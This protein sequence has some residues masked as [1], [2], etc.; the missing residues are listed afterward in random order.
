MVLSI[1]CWGLGISSRV[2]LLSELH[3]EVTF[4]KRRLLKAF[5]IADAASRMVRGDR[6]VELR[7]G[8]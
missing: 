1:V 2:K 5:I 4:R 7:C 8:S 6:N 3:I